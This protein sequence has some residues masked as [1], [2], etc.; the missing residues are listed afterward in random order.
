[1]RTLA[2]ALLAAILFVGCG[3]GT[4]SADKDGVDSDP[5]ESLPRG[6]SALEDPPFARARAVSV[7]TG[8][9]LFY[10]GGDTDYGATQHVE[11]ALY[12]PKAR[13]WRRISDGPLAGR[14][15]AG[16]VWTGDEVFV[17]GGWMSGQRSW[18]DG[19]LFEPAS[20]KWRMLPPSP[21]S[22][23]AAPVAVVWTGSEVLVWGG[24]SRSGEQR[25]G[26]AYDPKARRWR[27]LPSAPFGL[28][29]AEGIWTGNEMIVF[30]A[31]L[32]NNNRSDT[33]HARGL[34]YNPEKNSWR[35]ISEHRLSP[36]ASS[37]AWTG[38]E[39]LAWD[40]ELAASAYD[41]ARDLWRQVPRV[42]LRFCECYPRSAR[43]RES[44]MAWFFGQ[45]AVFDVA[46]STWG[47]VLKAPRDIFGRP[48]AAG[49][50]VLFAGAAH[51]GIGNA[52][53]AYRP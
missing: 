7:W 25:D 49:S 26:A 50:V 17:W 40:Y 52:L 15:S 48:V 9:E 41:P 28:N 16:A 24:T 35:V 47:R 2:F 13:S 1:M 10:W 22:P 12:D 38:K 46:T 11:G 53:W 37:I 6:W 5:W 4:R 29:Q 42:P 32:D 23:R 33:R 43:L 51:E 14:S 18:N 8:H 19:A 3:A 31:K 20:G 36:Q 27:E 21:L 45:G 44:I 34:A 39:V 30:G